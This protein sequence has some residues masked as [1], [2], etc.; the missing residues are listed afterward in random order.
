MPTTPRGRR[1][2]SQVETL[3]VNGYLRLD[4]LTANC[5]VRTVGLGWRHQYSASWTPDYYLRLH[6]LPNGNVP[7]TFICHLRIRQARIKYQ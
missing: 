4:H 7:Y 5:C 1:V 2:S 3:G 6:L